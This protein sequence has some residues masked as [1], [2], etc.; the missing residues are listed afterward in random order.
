L[1]IGGSYA[2]GINTAAYRNLKTHLHLDTPTELASKRSDIARV[3]EVIRNRLRI[4]TYPLLAGDPDGAV[5]ELPDGSYQDEWRVVRSRAEGGHYYVTQ[6]P[7]AEAG[8]QDLDRFPWPDPND[9]GWSRGL[10]EEAIRIHQDS[11]YALV[12]SLPVGFGHQSQFLRG[13]DQWLVDCALDPAFVGRLMDHVIEIHMQIAA[14]ILAELGD[15]VDVVLYADDMGFQ[16]RPILSPSMFRRLIKPRQKRFLEHI[17][18]R[19]AAK[20]LYHTCGSIYSLIPD[21]IEAGVDVL[22]PVQTTAAHMDPA[23]LKREFGRDL[24]F[25]GA[26]DTQRLLPQASPAEVEAQVRQLVETLGS[27]GG[28]VVSAANNI[29]ADTPAE[30]ILAMATGCQPSERAPVPAG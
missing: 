15:L 22:N 4:D 9:P 26:V 21:F 23:Q 17:K 27:D 5:L 12:L 2:T 29:Q 16:D 25:W 8:L 20:V 19:T 24:A 28:Y 10:L 3:D 13:Y 18:A 30:N 1:D 14:N 6:P 11:D 7:L